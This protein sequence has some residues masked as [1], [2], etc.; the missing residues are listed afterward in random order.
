MIMLA[1]PSGDQAQL[2]GRCFKLLGLLVEEV[3]GSTL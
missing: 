2:L 1:V 3:P